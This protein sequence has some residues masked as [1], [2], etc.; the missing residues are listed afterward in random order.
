MSSLHQASCRVLNLIITIKMYALILVTR[1]KYVI[2]PVGTVVHRQ[3]TYMGSQRP[4]WLEGGVRNFY[5]AGL[6]YGKWREIRK[7]AKGG[8]KK[9]KIS[10]RFR[11]VILK[12]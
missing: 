8:T 9:K 3:H 5:T 2:H 11:Y 6:H 7:V 10:A 4:L 12:Q 1:Q